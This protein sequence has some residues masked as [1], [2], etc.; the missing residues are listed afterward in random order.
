[1]KVR[2]H[3][4]IMLFVSAVMLLTPVNAFAQ[5]KPKD[6]PRT[7]WWQNDKFGMFIHW[8]V[9][10]VPA[11]SS[12][13]IAEWYMHNHK[14]PVP[15]Y[16]RFATQFNPVKFNADQWV[17]IAKDA[18]MKYI[19]ITSKHHDGF[20]MFDSKL[21]KYDIID[22]TPFSRDPMK[23]LADACK[24]HD[25]KL[26]FYHSIMDWHHPDYT[27]HREW[28]HKA[29]PESEADFDR[30]IEYMKGQLRE[31]VTNYAPVSVLWFDGGWEGNAEKH[32]SEEVV[33]MLR[34]L[35]PEII[36]N[37]RINL[38]EDHATPEQQIPM[39]ALPDDRLWETCMTMNNTWGYSRTDDNWKSV[40]DLVRKLVDIAHKGGNFLLNVGPTELGEIPQASIDRLSAIGEWMEVNGESIYGTSKSPWRRMLFDGRCTAAENMLYLHFFDWPSTP[41][42]L[43]GLR[44]SVHS[45]SLLGSTSIV[46]VRTGKDP[47]SD[48]TVQTVQLPTERPSDI[49]SVVALRFETVPEVV[50][51]GVIVTQSDDGSTVLKAFDA[52]IRGT[53]AKY[54]GRGASGHIG[55]W[56]NP[57]DYLEWTMVL[58]EGGTFAVMIT[59]A[60]EPESAGADYQ[61]IVGERELAG[62]VE[63]TGSGK[64]FRT[65]FLGRMRLRKGRYTATVKPETVAHDAVMNLKQIKLVPM[66]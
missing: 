56:T 33:A 48:G 20:C 45:A 29:R 58:N 14:I 63:D 53:R 4:L 65:R 17:R 28:E 60:C 52:N 6:D 62:T 16:E 36:I 37:D 11:D 13:G 18:G 54:E 21:T 39:D 24:R 8:G 47:F 23:E 25:I 64:K 12:K 30:Y 2:P 38:E 35:N 5:I 46:K 42:P 59:Y 57:D 43:P 22:A 27:P 7:A 44:T 1:M 40:E 26:G 19:I 31:L 51:L 50:D 41:V 55:Y 66:R 49:D 32:H 9:Y 34:S 10:A 61:V 15:E 3:I